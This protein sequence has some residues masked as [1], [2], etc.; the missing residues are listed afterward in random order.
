MIEINEMLIKVPGMTE[1][2]A[3]TMAAGIAGKMAA[4]IPADA[5]NKNIGELNIKLSLPPG[6]GGDAM[7]D[8]IARQILQQL[9][10]I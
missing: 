10:M 2:A 4:M 9:N 6:T 3:G 1:A 5:G 8:S 7:A